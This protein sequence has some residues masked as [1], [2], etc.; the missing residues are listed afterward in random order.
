MFLER[1]AAAHPVACTSA[2]PG[3]GVT[4]ADVLAEVAASLGITA[5]EAERALFADLARSH[6][7]RHVEPLSAA[8]T[9]HRYNLA[10]A[11]TVLLRATSLT[12]T[13]A[14][15][16]PARYRQ[17]FRFIKFYRL[18]HS[19][20]GTRTQGYT[21]RLDGPLSLFQLS[22]KY[23]LQIASFLPALLLCDG[24]TLHAELL[25]GTQRRPAVFRLNSGCGLVSHYPDKGVYITDEERHFVDRFSQ[26]D[27]N[28]RLERAAEI[29]DL[30]GHGVLIP[31]YVLR[32][33]ETARE[34]LL[35]IVGFWRKSYLESRLDV[36]NRHGPSNLILAVSTRLRSTREQ[37]SEFRGE[38]VMFRDLIPTKDVLERAE[39]VG[40]ARV[41]SASV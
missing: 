3:S 15:G 1:A 38:V 6:V 23:G 26:L 36:L 18:M 20:E 19:V 27:T 28:W 12:I 21:I 24:W 31:D 16:D 5:D 34:V 11:Q 13:I 32:H 30:D 14:P 39:R 33:A 29:V 17:L 25:W 37:L 9:I 2:E 41:G 7:L 35:E 10:L 4:R 8:A 22:S 40:R